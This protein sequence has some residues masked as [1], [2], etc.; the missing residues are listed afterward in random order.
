[1]A[2][3]DIEQWFEAQSFSNYKH[4]SYLHVK[5]NF[6]MQ[7]RAINTSRRAEEDGPPLFYF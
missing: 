2:Q 1:M 4:V 5:Q 7:L 3:N 6:P